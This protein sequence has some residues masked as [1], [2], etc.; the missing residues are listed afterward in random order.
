MTDPI[1]DP[2]AD[3]MSHVEQGDSAPATP[4]WAI[5]LGIIALVLILAVAATFAFGIQHNPGIH[6]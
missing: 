3:D 5:V 6:G 4:R 1:H 2:D